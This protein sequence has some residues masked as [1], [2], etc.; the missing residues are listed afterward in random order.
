MFSCGSVKV[1]VPAPE[2]ESPEVEIAPEEPPATQEP[3]PVPVPAPEPEPVP[4]PEP[5]PE[6][7][8]TPEPVQEQPVDDEYSRSVGEVAVSR[9]TFLDDKTKVLQIISELDVIMKDLNYKAWLPYVDQE[10]IDY[11]KLRKNLQKAEKRLPVK[12]VKLQNLEDFFKKFFVPARRG[13]S[14]T[15]IRYISDSYIKAVQVDEKKK[16]EIVYYFF[17]KINGKWMVHIPPVD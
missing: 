1:A 11:W 6:P 13:R 12:G 4:E 9:D 8:P 2:P 17:N 10:S 14:I 15:E 5:I 3:E 7:E 16:D